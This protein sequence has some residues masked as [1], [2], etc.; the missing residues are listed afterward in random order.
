M[1]EEFRVLLGVELES[2]AL[3]N[4]KSQIDGLTNIVKPIKIQIDTS[5]ATAAINALKSQIKSLGNITP[6]VKVGNTANNTKANAN[7][8]ASNAYKQIMQYQ[9]RINTAMGKIAGLDTTKD[10]AQIDTLNQRVRTLMGSVSELYSKFKGSFSDSQ[11]QSLQRA[12]QITGDKITDVKAKAVDLR[13]ELANSNKTAFNQNNVFD[14][15][16]LDASLQ[17]LKAQ[18][19]EVKAAMA[20]FNTAKSGMTSAIAKGDIEGIISAYDRYVLA[21]QNANREIKLNQQAEQAAARAAKERANAQKLVD[22]KNKLSNDMDAWLKQNSAAAKDYGAQIDALRAK[23]QSCDA[24]SLS[25]L[26]AEFQSITREAA[27]AGKNTQTF[28]DRLKAQMAKFGTYLTAATVFS[29]V[30]RTVKDMY[31]NVLQVDTA[32]TELYRVTD[33]SSSKYASLYS[34]MTNSAKQYGVALS[35]IIES[36]ASWVRLGFDADSAKRLAELTAQYQHV[37]DLDNGTAVENLVTAYKGFQDQ[38]DAAFQGDATAAV[39]RISDIYD[40]LG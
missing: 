6:K 33:L 16:S 34:E 25:H 7:T 2:G 12:F 31:D 15:K 28:G 11:L 23:I 14:T 8:A 19:Q 39:E 22:A 29:Y 1:A 17:R 38:L 20:E 26:R 4:I 5:S 18:S 32:M 9:Q 21:L 10:A 36:T 40:K 27:L 30:I 3:N 37:T 24:A 35:D 13:R